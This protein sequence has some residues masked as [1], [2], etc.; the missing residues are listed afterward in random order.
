MYIYAYSVFYRM[1]L[2]STLIAVLSLLVLTVPLFQPAAGVYIEKFKYRV[3]DKWNYLLNYQNS[4]LYVDMEVVDEGLIYSMGTVKEVSVIYVKYMLGDVVQ[5][6][7]PGLIYDLTFHQKIYVEKNS[8]EI[9]RV[10]SFMKANIQVLFYNVEMFLKE[11][12]DLE[13]RTG[14]G[15]PIDPGSLIK[16]AIYQETTL[17]QKMYTNLGV[18]TGL[19]SSETAN[20]TY[21][22]DIHCT[23]PIDISLPLGD[24]S[25][26]GVV[27]TYGT[28]F[29]AYYSMLLMIV[30][31]LVSLST[32]VG[33][34]FGD[35]DD[36][37]SD[38][39]EYD[40]SDY[41]R[42]AYYSSKTRQ[43]VQM[44]DLLGGKV[45][46]TWTLKAYYLKQVEKPLFEL[47]SY[48]YLVSFILVGLVVGGV[49]FYD[50]K[51]RPQTTDP[52]RGKLSEVID[53][54]E[55]K[56]EERQTEVERKKAIRAKGQQ[57][58]TP[59]YTTQRALY[60]QRDPLRKPRNA[61]GISPRAQADLYK[62]FGKTENTR[63]I[64]DEDYP[65][66]PPPEK[67]M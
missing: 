25:T 11:R 14:V 33:G 55:A 46:W 50:I 36:T 61:Y 32:L 66:P 35:D 43:P 37:G 18:D 54:V 23:G 8:L 64:F 30:N 27:T 42:E 6:E 10:E 28:G 40:Y 20:A 9:V 15:L 34:V 52:K 60:E 17:E 57:Y 12:D 31:T 1:R 67:K 19:P 21:W 29:P 53:K 39:E 13:Y 22:N 48:Y 41:S 26:Q 5:V 38:F 44:T 7:L 2:S 4:S 58:Y 65:A 56:L 59:E 51:L 24:F 16:Q 49:M 62:N 3:G 63:N 45:L 47:R